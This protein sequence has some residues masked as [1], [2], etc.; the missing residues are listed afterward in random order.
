MSGSVILPIQAILQYAN[1]LLTPPW[2]DLLVDVD[3]RMIE[4]AYEDQLLERVDGTRFAAPLSNRDYPDGRNHA[5]RVA[6]LAING[7]GEPISI[8]A[9]DI[10]R[11]HWPITDGNHRLAAAIILG[12]KEIKAEIG[13]FE[14]DVIRHFGEYVARQIFDADAEM[15]L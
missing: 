15:C 6:W 2:P 12:E 8:E 10:E 5:G 7:W 11:G 9:S 14:T 4:A 3:T 1:P 13:G